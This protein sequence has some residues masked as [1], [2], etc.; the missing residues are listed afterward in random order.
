MS[1][2]QET[3]L[4]YISGKNLRVIETIVKKYIRIPK[5]SYISGKNLRVIETYLQCPLRRLKIR[6]ISGKNLR[7]IETI[8]PKNKSL[9]RNPVTPAVRTWGWLKLFRRPGIKLLK[10]VTLAVRAWGWLKRPG[11]SISVG[12]SDCVTPVARTWGWLKQD[13]RYSFCFS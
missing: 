3:D 6:Y 10:P 5:E 8:L 4:S 12:I 7:V 9:S 2:S 11:V 13:F 1:I